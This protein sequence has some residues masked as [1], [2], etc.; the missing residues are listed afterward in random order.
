MI[1]TTIINTTETPLYSDKIQ[2]KIKIGLH[3]P[4]LKTCYRIFEFF[5]KNELK[6]FINEQGLDKYEDPEDRKH[7]LQK[8]FG[9]GFFSCL[10][11]AKR[12]GTDFFIEDFT[13]Y[14]DTADGR[15]HLTRK[16]I[17]WDSNILKQGLVNITG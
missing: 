8:F 3:D 2:E 6:E 12:V 13:K 15:N 7:I 10:L 14:A 11:R 5:D 17:Q 1:T 4:S 9:N 16:Y